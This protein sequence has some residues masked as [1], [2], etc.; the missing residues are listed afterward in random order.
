MKRELLNGTRRFSYTLTRKHV[1]RINARI[2]REGEIAVSAPSF[3]KVE[4]IDTFVLAN[5][6][7]LLLAADKQRAA[8]SN[9]P[10]IFDGAALPILGEQYR[11]CILHGVRRSVT[12]EE[13]KKELHLTLTE[14]DNEREAR[15][16]LSSHLEREAISLLTRLYDE[17]YQTYFGALFEK[18]KLRFRRMR[19]SW[20]NCRQERG[21]ITLNLRLLYAPRT[22]IE[23]VILHELVHMLHPDHSPR[24]WSV[25]ARYMPDYAAR[26]AALAKIPI[27]FDCFL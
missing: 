7:K 26:R 16:A 8:K 17:A 18:P 25:L 4:L 3:V 15:R 2:T 20:G 9:V 14:E 5:A 12:V 27:A 11:L 24:F 23:Y 6:S 13:K 21:I 1:K 19:S 22:A 10:L